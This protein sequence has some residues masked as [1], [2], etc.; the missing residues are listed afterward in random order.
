VIERV[1]EPTCKFSNAIILVGIQWKHPTIG[2]RVESTIRKIFGL[3][4]RFVYIIKYFFS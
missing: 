2:R 3:L 1:K 4:K